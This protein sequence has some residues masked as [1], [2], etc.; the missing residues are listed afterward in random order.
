MGEEVPR[1]KNFSLSNAL[2]ATQGATETQLTCVF[3]R[4]GDVGNGVRI[5]HIHRGRHTRRLVVIL[6]S[7]AHDTGNREG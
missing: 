6:L 7:H 5:P 3:L 4:G 1:A 2:W